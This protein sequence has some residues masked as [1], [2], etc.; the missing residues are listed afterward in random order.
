MNLLIEKLQITL[1]V[2]IY[3]LVVHLPQCLCLKWSAWFI[4]SNLRMILSAYWRAELFTTWMLMITCS[5]LVLN[6]LYY[7]N[8]TSLLS[9]I[10][11]SKQ[12]SQY[13]KAVKWY[14]HPS[15]SQILKFGLSHLLE[16]FITMHLLYREKHSIYSLNMLCLQMYL[17]SYE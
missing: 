3:E 13:L 12:G 7:S 10:K 2:S 8:V 14:A 1:P 16:I 9:E 15:S 6:V 4:W 17:F 5:N 11:F